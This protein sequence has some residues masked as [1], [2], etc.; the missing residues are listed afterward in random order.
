MTKAD[1]LKGLLKGRGPDK[2]TWDEALKRSGI[3]PAAIIEYNVPDDQSHGVTIETMN[4]AI[5]E[6][7]SK[8]GQK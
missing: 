7:A 2:R 6:A 3:D 4:Q 8:A 5:R 1:E